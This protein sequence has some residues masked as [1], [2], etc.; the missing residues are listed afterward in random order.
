MP[1]ELAE[2]DR[3]LQLLGAVCQAGSIKKK[4]RAELEALLGC[5]VTQQ[6]ASRW[7]TQ[8][9]EIRR[10][11]AAEIKKEREPENPDP[12]PSGVSSHEQDPA[13][14]PHIRRMAPEDICDGLLDEASDL[15]DALDSL[16]FGLRMEL[17][18]AAEHGLFQ[19]IGTARGALDRIAWM[20]GTRAVGDATGR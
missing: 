17:G 7:K 10:D 6:L 19:E 5:R 2:L 3:A 14:G 9:K 15:R 11:M 18:V 13:D 16:A 12:P 20:L 8:L 1:V 4:H